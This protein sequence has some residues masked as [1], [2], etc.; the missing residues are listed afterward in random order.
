LGGGF[1][2]KSDFHGGFSLMK[3]LIVFHLDFIQLLRFTTMKGN[4]EP[5]EANI[6][7][8]LLFYFK[9]YLYADFAI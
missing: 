1:H 5:K 3:F 9:S 7:N 6:Q 4:M 8:N 2:L